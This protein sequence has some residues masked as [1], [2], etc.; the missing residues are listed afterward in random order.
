MNVE[1]HYTVFVPASNKNHLYHA[2]ENT[3]SQNTGQTLYARNLT[4]SLP[5]VRSDLIPAEV[6][7][8]I[9]SFL[10]VLF[11]H[12]KAEFQKQKMK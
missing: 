9:S 12:G 1:Q 8:A 3:D 4:P 5:I 7:K 11:S 6:L 2:I 10:Q